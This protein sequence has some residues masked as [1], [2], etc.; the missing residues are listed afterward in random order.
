M[1]NTN[2]R[3]C[4]E[5]KQQ[6]LPTPHND[7]KSNNNSSSSI[8]QCQQLPNGHTSQS[9]RKNRSSE[10]YRNMQAM[11][12]SKMPM[13]IH[14]TRQI[15]PIHVSTMQNTPP[16]LPMPER[17]RFHHKCQTDIPNGVSVINER[18][19]QASNTNTTNRTTNRHCPSS[20]NTN[21]KR[22]IS[23]SSLNKISR[24]G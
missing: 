12:Q 19:I 5:A 6:K 11:L 3:T 8:E 9:Q 20:D 10:N 1:R 18:H 23:H 15:Q 7:K 24:R 13:Q 14:K 16:V 22:C 2:K 4:K 21:N 17:Y